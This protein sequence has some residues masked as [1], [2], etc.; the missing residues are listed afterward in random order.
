MERTKEKIKE[1]K[2]F[3]ENQRK[4]NEELAKL[5]NCFKKSLK[6]MEIKNLSDIIEKGIKLLSEL[7]DEE[8]KKKWE[9]IKEKFTAAKSLLENIIGLS[10][11]GMDA[12]YNG[13]CSES[14]ESFEHITTELEEYKKEVEI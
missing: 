7:V 9:S 2:L 3:E 1:R 5:E 10:K 12:L 14:L 4:I 13:S 11:K 6:A 8:V